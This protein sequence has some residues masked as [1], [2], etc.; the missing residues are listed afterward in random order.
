MPDLKKVTVRE[1]LKGKIGDYVER[2][3]MACVD[4]TNAMVD[5]TVEL[6]HY[7]EEGRQLFPKVLV[8][9]D[10][11]A[12][13]Q[14]LLVGSPIEFGRGARGPTTLR[15]AVKK[16]APIARAGWSMYVERSPGEFR[17]GVFREPEEPTTVDVRSSLAALEAGEIKAFFVCQIADRAV[18]FVGTGDRRLHVHLSSA[19]EDQPAPSVAIDALV[20]AATSDAPA[21]AREPLR[22]FLGSTLARAFIYGHGALIAVLPAGIPVNEAFAS[23]GVIFRSPIDLSLLVNGYLAERKASQMAALTANAALLEGMLASD[24][25]TLLG[26]DGALLG[27]NV[28]VR[29]P[30]EAG[31]P[32]SQLIG[33]ARRRAF[34]ELSRLVDIAA[35]RCAFIRS[36][37]GSTDF[38]KQVVQ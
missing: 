25:I 9:D 2:L 16:C 28:F 27:F 1:Q 31:V 7:E 33:G 30:D 18:E 36:T 4:T 38:R 6:A 26:A 10:L 14:V 24:G 5:L 8:C 29:S 21:T 32:A 19:H 23:D 13:L 15:Q 22:S 35:I 11:E 12:A 34:R 20:D 17:F 37:D 3:Q